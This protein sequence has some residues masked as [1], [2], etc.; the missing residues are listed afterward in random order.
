MIHAALAVMAVG[1]SGG[2]AFVIWLL[3]KHIRF[4]A[5][6][7]QML[8]AALMATKNTPYASS[9]AMLAATTPGDAAENHIGEVP[10]DDD[11]IVPEGSFLL[12]TEL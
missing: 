7:N 11:P 10:V 1:L 8:T 12:G 6:Q 2:P 5:E 3:I 9:A 4:Q